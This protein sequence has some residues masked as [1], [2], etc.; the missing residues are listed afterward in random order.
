V[1]RG[2]WSCTKERGTWVDVGRRE[3]VVRRRVWRVGARKGMV[4]WVVVVVV[5]MRCLG[6]V[7]G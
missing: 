6:E 4:R 1:R 2:G 7:E 3:V 5:L